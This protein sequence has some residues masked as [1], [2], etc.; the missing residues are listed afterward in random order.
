MKKKNL[1][2]L[3]I[4]PFL[5]SLFC[6]FAVNVTYNRIDVDISY[7]EWDYN[8]MEAFQI[9]ESGYLLKADG[10]N[11]RY[12]KATDGGELVWS[13]KNKS[14]EEAEPCAEYCRGNRKNGQKGRILH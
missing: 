12:Y 14:T 4:F 5:I 7:I 6:I 9:S 10:V 1:A 13:V 2:I 3:L 8:D 11:Q